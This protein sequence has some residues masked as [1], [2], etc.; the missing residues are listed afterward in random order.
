MTIINNCEYCFASLFSQIR[1]FFHKYLLL[2][3][4]QIPRYLYLSTISSV[5]LASVKENECLAYN[6]LVLNH[7]II[8]SKYIMY[9]YIFIS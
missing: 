3:P 5:F 7:Y 1:F 2:L 4:Y 8:I 9:N 6:Y